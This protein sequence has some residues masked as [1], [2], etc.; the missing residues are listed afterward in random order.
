MAEPTTE[1]KMCPMLAMGRLATGGDA[2]L[3]E[4][5]AT[6]GNYFDS[7]CRREACEWFTFDAEKGIHGCAVPALASALTAI[8]REM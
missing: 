3:A 7:H 4:Q 2:F 5:G 6:P 1:P 8:W